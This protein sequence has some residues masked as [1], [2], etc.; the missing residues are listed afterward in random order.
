MVDTEVIVLLHQCD[1]TS[2]DV[3]RNIVVQTFISWLDSITKGNL[4]HNQKTEHI[5]LVDTI[6]TFAVPSPK[7]GL[8][9]ERSN[10]PGRQHE[11]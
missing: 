9:I 5:G 2:L 3:T 10:M 11:R 4:F 6:Y 8:L 7:H 1:S